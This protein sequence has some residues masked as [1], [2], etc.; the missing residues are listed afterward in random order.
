MSPPHPSEDCFRQ[1]KAPGPL[2]TRRDED[3]SREAQYSKVQKRL[4]NVCQVDFLAMALRIMQYSA[5]LAS[6]ASV[7]L[8]SL[9]VRGVPWRL[10][11]ARKPP[12]RWRCA[13]PT[14]HLMLS[15][16]LECRNGTFL[17]N[18]V[19]MPTHRHL[20]APVLPTAGRADDA[21]DTMRCSV[22]SSV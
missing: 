12:G 9:P 16:T 17:V 2:W 22:E 18:T 7:L 1:R 10:L 3:W 13:P 4:E 19:E 14:D 21:D 8:W 15:P 11:R 6:E 20:D 5:L